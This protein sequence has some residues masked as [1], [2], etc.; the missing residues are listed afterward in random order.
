MKPQPG[1]AAIEG[2][3]ATWKPERLCAAGMTVVAVANQVMPRALRLLT[4]SG[5]KS[6]MMEE[7]ARGFAASN[8]AR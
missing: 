8:A 4:K 1:R 2:T 5:G 7:R 6:P 3:W